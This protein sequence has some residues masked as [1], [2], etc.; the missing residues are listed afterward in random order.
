MRDEVIAIRDFGFRGVMIDRLF[1]P[2]GWT[3]LT[4]ANGSGKSTLIE[5]I[6]GFHPYTGSVLIG[7]EMSDASGTG[8][9]PPFPDRGFIFTRVFDEI[10]S[11]LRFLKMTCPETREKVLAISGHMGLSGLLEREVSTLSGGEKVIV[12]LAAA[13]ISRPDLLLVDEA[14]SSLDQ[15]TRDTVEGIIRDFSPRYVIEATHDM[16]RA[17]WMDHVVFLD[18]GKVRA[19][20]PPREVFR[21][22]K[23]TAFEPLRVIT[24]AVDL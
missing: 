5:C 7:D 16:D 8:W 13:L 6:A 12:S 24:G 22:L 17:L 2:K 11:S 23:G 21:S 1:I 9:L 15:G 4:G 19:S 14:F 10:A 20:G 3:A 18:A